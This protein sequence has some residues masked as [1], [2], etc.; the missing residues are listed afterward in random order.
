MRN[1]AVLAV[2]GIC[3]HAW[4]FTAALQVYSPPIE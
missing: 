1:L 4:Q 3:I 2:L